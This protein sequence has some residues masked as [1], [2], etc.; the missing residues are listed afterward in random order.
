VAQR[1]AFQATGFKGTDEYTL[2]GVDEST[3]AGIASGPG[4]RPGPVVEVIAANTGTPG[5]SQI[6]IPAT[7]KTLRWTP[8]RFYLLVTTRRKGFAVLRLT[9]YPAWRILVNGAEL[10]GPAHR[11]DGL[12]MLPLVSGQNRIEI[13]WRITRDQQTGIALTLIALA[14][15]LALIFAARQN[16]QEVPLP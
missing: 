3:L 1:A 15:T 12:L 5:L 6:E 16:P 11:R 8:E 9:G 10:E 4:S 14:V 2:K 13:R 7:V